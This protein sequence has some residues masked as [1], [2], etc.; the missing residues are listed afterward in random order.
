MPETGFAKTTRDISILVGKNVTCAEIMKAIADADKTVADVRLV[1]IFESDKLGFD[2]KS[3]AFNID[4]ASA[5][6]DV[7]DA[8]TDEVMNRIV[9]VLEEKFSAKRR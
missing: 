1:D 2:K 7:T 3:M 9:S 5:E 6:G 4:F 8:M